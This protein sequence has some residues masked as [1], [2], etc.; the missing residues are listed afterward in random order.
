MHIARK[1]H[2]IKINTNPLNLMGSDNHIG[3]EDL[4]NNQTLL[5]NAVHR[6]N[7]TQTSI[8]GVHRGFI[9]PM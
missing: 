9:K 6:E 8:T 5:M 3:P 7:N 1:N 4:G 2:Y